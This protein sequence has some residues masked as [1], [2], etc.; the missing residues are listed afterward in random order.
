MNKRKQITCILL[1]TLLLML[2]LSTGYAEHLPAVQSGEII[3]NN[4]LGPCEAHNC[5]HPDSAGG[6]RYIEYEIDSS[7]FHKAYKYHKYNCT[8]CGCEAWNQIELC[9]DLHEMNDS[10]RSTSTGS[11]SSQ[12]WDIVTTTRR[13]SMCGYTTSSSSNTN[14]GSHYSSTWVDNGHS[15]MYHSF[16]KLCD[17]CRYRFAS[18]R[19]QCPGNGD[20]VA[21]QGILPPEVTE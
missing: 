5:S 9:Y 20:H 19:L 15:G 8:S 21:P 10:G 7:Y 13:C 12:H 4:T 14:Y 16:Y 18:T 11:S 1:T 2:T 17:K 3:E 6:V